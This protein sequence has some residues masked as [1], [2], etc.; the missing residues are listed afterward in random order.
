MNTDNFM[1]SKI[2]CN[3]YLSKQCKYIYG[4][5][6]QV[7]WGSTRC[8]DYQKDYLWKCIYT[9]YILVVQVCW[10]STTR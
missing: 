4:V 9:L 3:F 10:G 2:T 7:Y 5:V 8:Y 6:V 1:L